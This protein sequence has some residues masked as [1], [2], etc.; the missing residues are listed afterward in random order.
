MVIRQVALSLYNSLG[1]AGEDNLVSRTDDNFVIVNVFNSVTSSRV[2]RNRHFARKEEL[3]YETVAVLTS[4][5][6]CPLSAILGDF[7]QVTFI[8][9]K[10]HS[11]DAP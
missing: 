5:T 2:T 8:A 10:Y 11:F 7:L 3:I 4:N 1:L 9:L 6:T